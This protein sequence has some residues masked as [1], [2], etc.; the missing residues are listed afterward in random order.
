MN[1]HTRQAYIARASLG[2]F[3]VSLVGVV[4]LAVERSQHDE[5]RAH[6]TS[7]QPS[8]TTSAVPAEQ[9]LAE[10]KQESWQD[11]TV[12]I[13]AM[14]AV[15]P[16][17]NQVAARAD[18]CYITDTRTGVDAP[19]AMPNGVV[20][21]STTPALDKP[22][23]TIERGPDCGR[24]SMRWRYRTG[25]VVSSSAALHDGAAVIGSRDG[26]LYALNLTDGEARWKNEGH[27]AIDVIPHIEG[28]VVY[29][30][31]GQGHLLAADVR[32]GKTLR[33]FD[34]EEPLVFQSSPTT[35]QELLV[36]G[37]G[38][39]RLRAWNKT[40]GK[41]VWEYNPALWVQSS[42]VIRNG[43]AYIGSDDGW[44][45]AVD[46]RTG[47]LKWKFAAE[48]PDDP[49][50]QPSTT[51]DLSI[52][53]DGHRSNVLSTPRF[54]K[55]MA[56]ITSIRGVVYGVNADS[57]EEVWRHFGERAV[58]DT[59]VSADGVVYAHSDGAVLRAY[60]ALTG[61][62]LWITKTGTSKNL[63]SGSYQTGSAAAIHG[64]TVIVG[65]RDGDITAYNRRTGQYIWSFR[66]GLW[67]QS[68]PKIYGDVLIVGSNDG[69]VYA[70]NLD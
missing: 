40:T 36:S 35:Y 31:T 63:W 64:D 53:P 61:R 32:T 54:Y 41:Q 57:G 39:N 48:L 21:P 18:G 59:T 52:T 28:D 10:M 12:E 15:W 25:D 37:G 50:L 69:W 65:G 44:L 42:V 24:G 58:T 27:S 23:G 13:G 38:G 3:A 20:P 30:G 1:N 56:Y 6:T 45:H 66:T 34:N 62:V 55:N 16:L 11:Y 49:N 47:K 14:P 19:Q 46:A 5:V 70:I 7:T 68:T 67:V 2:V 9:D 22:V 43:V 17:P 51:V 8:G 4:V 33:R 26:V 29:F 60:D